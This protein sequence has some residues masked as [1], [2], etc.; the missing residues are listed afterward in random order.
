MNNPTTHL[1]WETT[2]RIG[3]VIGL[4]LG[5]AIGAA[6][7]QQKTESPGPAVEPGATVQIEYTATDQAGKVV[8][9]NKG[10]APLTFTEGQHQIIPGLE[11]ALAGMHP[12]EEK[13]VTVKPAD[14]Y[15]EVNPAAVIEVPKSQVPAAALK[16]GTELI[17]HNQA[18]QKHIVTVKEIKE[19][20]VVLDL[21][22][23]LAGKTIIFTVK[24]M[25]VTP[26]TK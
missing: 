21:N 17:A 24:V 18:G 4:M 13:Q 14:A 11:E 20:T 19:K 3:V 16:V 10:K 8:D 5:L 6:E 15:G 2:M 1:D 25:S 22:H 12:G 26:P 9:S 23:P 7:A